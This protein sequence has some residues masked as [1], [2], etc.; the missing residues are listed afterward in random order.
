MQIAEHLLSTIGHT[1]LVRLCKLARNLDAEVAVKVEFLNPSGSIKDRIALRMIEDAERAGVLRP[2]MEIVEASTGNTAVSLAF[3]GAIK[4]YRVHLFIPRKAF[5]EERVK[6]MT[7]FGAVVTLVESDSAGDTTPDRASGGGLHGSVVEVTPRV[8]CLQ[9]ECSSPDVWWARQFSNPSNV[10]AHVDGTGRE[11]IEQTDGYVHAFVAAIGTCGTLI[12]VAQAL[13]GR[14][15][16]VQIVAVEPR[17]QPVIQD[18]KLMVPVVEGISG[19]LLA[20][21][22]DQR[23]ATRI[24]RVSQDEAIAMAHRLSEEEGLLC[25]LS[26]G[27]NV[28]AALEVARELGHGQRV[29]TVLP[30]SRDRYLFKEQLTT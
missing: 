14:N 26:S 15:P 11:I 19:G 21:M 8:R 25:G 7:S 27:A 24:I 13:R 2:G 16:D 30:D 23:V 3:V 10:A 4:G 6:L 1:P 18:G 9:R 12:G 22:V 17:A 29:V 20:Q 28:L 5:S